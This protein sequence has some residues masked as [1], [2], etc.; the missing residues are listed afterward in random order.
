MDEQASAALRREVDELGRTFGAV[1]ERYAGAAGLDLVEQVRALARG[2]RDGDA[3]AGALL[4]DLLRKLD[5]RQLRLVVRSFS[6]FL[7]LANLAEDRQRVRV[8]QERQQA[9]HP[10]PRRESIRDAIAALRSREFS[11]AEVESLLARIRIELVLTAHPTE[12][13]RRSVRRLLGLM[14]ETLLR[15]DDAGD[16]EQQAQCGRQ[17][18]SELELL[19]LTNFL[20]TSRPT[21]LQEVTRGLAFLPILWD[22]AARLAADLRRALAEHYPTVRSESTTLIG[23]GSWIGGDR[24]GNP[25]VTPAVTEE[26]L[27]LQRQQ[28]LGMHRQTCRRLLQVLSVSDVEAP[29][30]AALTAAVEGA[31]AQFGELEQLVA[32]HPSQETQR[33]WLQVVDW[34]LGQ[35]E[36]VSLA[37]GDGAVVG[38]YAG[39]GELLHDAALLAESL[40][41]AGAQATRDL[42]VDPWLDQIRIFGFHATRLDVRQHASVYRTAID[43]L[44]RTAGRHDDAGSLD[45]AARQELLSHTLGAAIAGIDD[46]WSPAT[47]ETLELFALLRRTGRLWGMAALGEHVVSMTQRA[48]DLLGVLWLWRWSE[49]VDGGAAGDRELRLPMVPLFETIGDLRGAAATLGELLDA[50]AYREHL[51]GLSD[52]QTVMIGYSDST[53]DGG[54]LAAQ[55]ALHRAQIDLHRAAAERGVNVTFFHGRGGSLGRG[56]GPA[57]RSVLS[58]PQEA[59]NGS[60]RLTEQGEVLAERYDNPVIAHRH[61]EQLA[62]SAV[63]AASRRR[64]TTRDEWRMLLERMAAESYDAYRRLVD[65]R[66]FYEFYRTATPI[67]VIERLPIGSRPAKRRSGGRIEDLRAIPWVFSWTQCRSL[68]PAWYGLGSAYEA[69]IASG[70]GAGVSAADTAAE[71]ATMYRKWQFFA[72]TIDN[73]ALALAK[74]NMRMF[75]QYAKLAGDVDGAGE[76]AEAIAAEFARSRQAVLAITGGRELLDDVPWLQRSIQV[77]NGYVDPLNLIQV[78]LLRRA[79]AAAAADAPAAEQEDLASLADLTV[80]GLSTGMRTTG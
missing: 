4:N 76:I 63:T 34:R 41:A 57:A 30:G 79:R 62:W 77:R 1:I 51:R 43:E 67:G 50:P 36:Q 40:S 22:E 10:Q 71:I 33:R 72:S 20:R 48:S 13:K 61:L 9:A 46:G 29:A 64:Q 78:E 73:A 45:E 15:R 2:L 25:F 18:Q 6:T 52:K 69:A 3:E 35:T 59:F 44:L 60:M 66:A 74:A 70:A 11:A 7:E 14:R 24:D 26:T 5:G 47:R 16:V 39:C 68:L 27:R 55:W 28:A 23:F 21:V 56:G 12:A 65:H 31:V 38:A 58:L 37:A 42:E 32:A 80:H 19:W 75:A 53:K 49:S 17:L 8:L 54:Y